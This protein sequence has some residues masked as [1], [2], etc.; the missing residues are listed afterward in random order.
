MI[1]TL[2]FCNFYKYCD[3]KLVKKI[4]FAILLSYNYNKGGYWNE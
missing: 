4:N 1:I 2:E 3:W